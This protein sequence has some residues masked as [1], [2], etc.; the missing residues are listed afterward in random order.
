LSTPQPLAAFM[1][2]RT[3]HKVARLTLSTGQ[4]RMGLGDG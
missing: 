3:V 2:G 1:D 4:L